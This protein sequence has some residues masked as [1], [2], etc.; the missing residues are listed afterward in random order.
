MLLD[1]VEL[2]VVD[3]L[4]V[5]D[6]FDVEVVDVEVLVDVVVKLVLLEVVEVND[7]LEVVVVVVYVLELVVE[8]LLED[9]VLLVV[10]E[11]VLLDMGKVQD[12]FIRKDEVEQ[13]SW[14]RWCRAATREGWLLHVCDALFCCE[15]VVKWFV[16]DNVWW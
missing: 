15:K 8:V 14:A 5:L 4:E 13:P 2:D 16:L 7:L 6:E 9:V 3:E 1:E 11:L 12:I 10:D